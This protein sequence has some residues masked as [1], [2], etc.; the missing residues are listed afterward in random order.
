MAIRTLSEQ[1]GYLGTII[2]DTT[3]N[4]TITDCLNL[5]LSELY[6]SHPWSSLR[7]KT[8]FSTVASQE[9]YRL[10]EEVEKIMLLRQ[11]TTPTVLTYVPDRDFYRHIPAPEDRGTGT[12]RYYRQWEE[13]GF[14]T[15]LA[16]DDTI[17]VVSS[18]TSDGSG[19]NVRVW[20]RNTNGISIAETLT[21]NGTTAVTSTNTFDEASLLRVSKSANTT[22]VISVRRTTGSTVLIRIAPTEAS[23][24]SKIIALYPIPSA[25][26]TMYLEY[27]ERL[28]L[29]VADADVPQF[30]VQWNWVLQE[31][32]LQHLWRFKRED[33]K[34]IA[35]TVAFQRGL[36]LMKQADDPVAYDMVKVVGRRPL[37]LPA[38][39][40]YYNDSVDDAFPS[41]GVGW[42]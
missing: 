35:A 17:E 32:A 30:D 28:Q 2:K 18:S 27:L 10:D 31:G 8:T 22:G 40:K 3:I 29:L 13:T 11:R 9:E 41:Y 7:R 1:R 37:M 21:L 33:E 36:K 39:V 16:A 26:I 20:G 14:T 15:S 19:F 38:I 23:P 12:P 25:V 42:W 5:A 6:Y 4:S 24:R 34:A